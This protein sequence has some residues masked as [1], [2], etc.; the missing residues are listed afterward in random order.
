[1][2]FLIPI[3]ILL[4]LLLSETGCT[5]KVYIPVE[6]SSVS[7]DTIHISSLRYDS[8]ILRDSITVQQ[9]AD[10]ILKSVVRYRERYRNIYDTITRIRH[11]S[12]YIEKPISVDI[13]SGSKYS[14]IRIT[15]FLIIILFTTLSLILLMRNILKK[16]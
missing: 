16:K 5:R 3:S 9:N 8:I 12:I 10:T 4:L 11:D 15:L 14:G 1:M 13:P 2:R 7:R 6:S